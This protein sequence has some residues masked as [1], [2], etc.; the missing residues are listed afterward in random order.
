MLF[1]YQV[2]SEEN[3]ICKHTIAAVF[4]R[5]SWEKQALMPQ[6][7]GFKVW[8]RVLWEF[9]R[10]IQEDPQGQNHF[11]NNMTM[12]LEFFILI[13]SSVYGG[14]FQKLYDVCECN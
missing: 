14:N 10:P 3:T 9:L 11:Q 1:W 13:M 8:S 12:S 7:N 4:T 5:D 6:G 2:S